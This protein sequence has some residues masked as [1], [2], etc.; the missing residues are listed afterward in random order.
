MLH[1]RRLTRP[2]IRLTQQIPDF[3]L[4]IGDVLREVHGGSL[5]VLQVSGELAWHARLLGG[6]QVARTF[7]ALGPEGVLEDL[8]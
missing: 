3:V 8:L 2:L 5:V 1:S 4:H 6:T 7:E